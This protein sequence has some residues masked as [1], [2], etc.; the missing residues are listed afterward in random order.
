MVKKFWV[1]IVQEGAQ[2]KIY[3]GY[4]TPKNCAAWAAAAL[5]DSHGNRRSKPGRF[6][7][8]DGI[9]SSLK[10]T[11]WV[12]KY[13]TS[14]SEEYV[15]EVINSLVNKTEYGILSM[16]TFINAVDWPDVFLAKCYDD[17]NRETLYKTLTNY[18]NVILTV[19]GNTNKISELKWTVLTKNID[20]ARLVFIKTCKKGMP[21]TWLVPGFMDNSEEWFEWNTIEKPTKTQEHETSEI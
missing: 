17:K 13:Y 14:I 11:Q 2:Y 3:V 7:S 19:L 9:I 20:K 15:T 6:F 16:E 8:A 4:C 5:F 21:S 12:N 18:Q 1:A 10:P